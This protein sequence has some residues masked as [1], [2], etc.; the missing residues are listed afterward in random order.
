MIVRLVRPLVGSRWLV[1]APGF[2]G[3]VALRPELARTIET[4]A[5]SFHAER[6]GEDWVIGERAPDQPW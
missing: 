6:V 2:A 1:Y 5:A 4:N 3:F